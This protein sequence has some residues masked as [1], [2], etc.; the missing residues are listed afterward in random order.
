MNLQK[1][2]RVR[3][4]PSPTG[5]TH[6]GSGRTALYNYLLA[7]QSGGQFILRIEDTDRKRY[8]PEAESELMR[9]LH[10]LGLNWD[11]G[12]DVGGDYGPYRQTERRAIYEKYARQLVESGHAY[13]CFCEPQAEKKDAIEKE[14]SK[15][16]DTCPYREMPLDQADTRRGAGER[17]VI[18]FK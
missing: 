4:A 6:L 10:W 13:Y 9:S 7:R 1:P 14:R 17:P 2:M 16:R 12:P 3:F 11:E 8:E 18:R 15:H 5:R